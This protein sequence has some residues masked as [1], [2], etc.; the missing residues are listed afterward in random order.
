MC[1]NDAYKVLY[2]RHID[3]DV[4]TSCKQAL[5]HGRGRGHLAH[6]YNYQS[7]II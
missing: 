6:V 5:Q 4:N 7:D 2:V 3:M 1:E